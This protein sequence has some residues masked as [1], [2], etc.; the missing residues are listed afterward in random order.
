MLSRINVRVV[1]VDRE[2]ISVV[3]EN[4]QQDC[5]RCQAGQGC[6]NRPWFR[7]LFRNESALTLPTPDLRLQV[8]DI[9]LMT[10]HPSTVN[11]LAILTYAVP[12]TAFILALWLAQGLEH[13]VY[14][15]LFAIAAMSATFLLSR[16]YTARLI[17]RKIKLEP[18][19]SARPAICTPSSPQAN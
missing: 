15:L 18:A 9:A 16:C 5:P 6:G 11:Q 13:E 8:G 19:I 17:K 14:Q 12:L 7:G 1:A 10:L 3:P 4:E 2:T